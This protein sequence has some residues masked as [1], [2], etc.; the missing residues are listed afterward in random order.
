M[1][2]FRETSKARGGIAGRKD[3]NIVMDTSLTVKVNGTKYRIYLKYQM[4]FQ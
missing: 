2:H 4:Q 1:L 3:R